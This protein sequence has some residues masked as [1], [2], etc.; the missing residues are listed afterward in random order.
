M[1][2]LRAIGILLLATV[3]VACGGDE[4]QR[5]TTRKTTR[6]GGTGSGGSTTTATGVVVVDL[7]ADKNTAQVG[8]DINLTAEIWLDTGRTKPVTDGTLVDFARTGTAAALNVGQMA[9][10]GGRAAVRLN[11]L[12]VGS[13]TVVATALGVSS[14][15]LSLSFTQA[16]G[17]GSTP[18]VSTILVT[19]IGKTFV[20]VYDAA[21]TNDEVDL[22]IRAIDN[23][24]AYMANV[25][26]TVS[27][28]AGSLSRSKVTTDAN[29]SATVRYTAGIK[30]ET[31]T[32][33]VADGST[34][35]T[36]EL[37]VGPGAP[38]LIE[39]ADPQPAQIGI[40]G[41]GAQESS[42]I[43]FRIKDRYGNPVSD[44][45]VVTFALSPAVGGATVQPTTTKTNGGIVSPVINAGTISGQVSLIATLPAVGRQV[46]SGKVTIFGGRPS[47]DRFELVFQP[48]K[49][50]MSGF[51]ISGLTNEMTIFVAD[52][53][54]NPPVP[55][56]R[57]YVSCEAG[58]CG[59]NTT[60]GI[61]LDENGQGTFVY[62]TAHSNALYYHGPGTQVTFP[63]PI[64]LQHRWPVLGDPRNGYANIIAMVVG[65]GGYID[66]NANGIFDGA[67]VPVN[68]PP[69]P[70]L[71]RNY[72]GVYS[73]GLDQFRDYDLN[74][75]WDD[76]F[77]GGTP[78]YHA[79]QWIWDSRTVIYATIPAI[80]IVPTQFIDFNADGVYDPG[81]DW[82]AAGPK[83]AVFPF[84]SPATLTVLTYAGPVS[85]YSNYVTTGTE[86]YVNFSDGNDNPLP[87]G[88][89]M[90]FG[91]V[92]NQVGQID[93]PPAEFLEYG[94]DYLYPLPPRRAIIKK[95]GGTSQS[96]L[97]CASVELG[98]VA[99]KIGVCETVYFF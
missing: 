96:S 16:S 60:D 22:L 50:V 27:A 80:Q 10:S 34:R 44:D 87:Q 66:L 71:D 4:N 99:G 31:V 77:H 86:F 55:G 98:D 63:S 73:P 79:S 25:T 49:L 76:H 69:E 43:T 75:T 20:T 18:Q 72:D 82:A 46:S 56:T 90:T 32:I 19:P 40:R 48:G 47:A 92:N 88:S 15:L 70:F 2:C 93:A 94:A 5:P 23:A 95:T 28:S 24:G 61:P 33:T 52:R 6:T 91:G 35:G 37:D 59:A 29:G 62:Y 8:Q 64:G 78:Q 13:V 30:A 84:P 9:T 7:K 68:D 53:Y 65:E 1:N 57:V 74:N 11:G 85:G 81:E 21:S 14:S 45:T 41:S 38:V 3:A 17:G 89:K 58:I 97:L 51:T 67:D 26:L 36:V 83:P 54:G 12:Q 42:I 39:V